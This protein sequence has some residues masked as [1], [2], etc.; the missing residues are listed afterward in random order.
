[1]IAKF[2]KTVFVLTFMVMHIVYNLTN[3][4]VVLQLWIGVKLGIKIVNI[5]PEFFNF[6]LVFFEVLFTFGRSYP[7]VLIGHFSLSVVNVWLWLD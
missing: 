1:M 2:L 7:Q 5:L 6:G 4:F 3:I